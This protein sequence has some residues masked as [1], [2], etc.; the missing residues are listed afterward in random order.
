MF[1]LLIRILCDIQPATAT[2]A[3]FLFG[4]TEDNDASVLNKVQQ[5][6]A[7]KQTDLALFMDTPP[8]NGHPGFEVWKRSLLE[9]GVDEKNIAG[10]PMPQVPVLHTLVEAEAVVTYARQH[11]FHSL[12]VTA[13]PFHQPRA[14]MTAITAALRI[15]PDLKIYSQTGT[16]LSWLEEAVHSQGKTKGTR[17][18]LLAGELE[19]IEKYQKQGDLA[20]IE[21]VLA[22]LNRRDE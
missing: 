22:Y 1:E 21:E 9:L 10:V 7:S 20:S 11:H 19:R 18:Q 16:P 15:Y 4:Q 13:A 5:L 6:L 3:T 8:A 2:N 14:F 12:Y 17:K